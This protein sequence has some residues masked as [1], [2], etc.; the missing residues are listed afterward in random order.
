LLK[1][2]LATHTASEQG[3]LRTVQACDAC[4]ENKTKCDGGERCSLCIKR[5]ITCIISRGRPS[6]QKAGPIAEE[7]A[8]TSEDVGNIYEVNNDQEC[9]DISAKQRSFLGE[10][11][12]HISSD[13]VARAGMSQILDLLRAA[14][15]VKD[16]PT[17][18]VSDPVKQWVSLCAETYF[19]PFHDRWPLIHAPLFDETEDSLF[20]VSAVVMIGSILRDKD[21]SVRDL[22]LEVHSHLHGY[23]L[24]SLVATLKELITLFN[25]SVI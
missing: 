4:Y 13:N 19:G 11:T 14:S 5:G 1:R 25:G 18:S 6:N 10:V 7:H 9:Q 20:V 24:E 16:C 8:I 2:H 21:S 15:T 12:S 17:L 23:C 3:P 22:A